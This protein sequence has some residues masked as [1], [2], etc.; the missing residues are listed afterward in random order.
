MIIDTGNI[1]LIGAVL[2]FFSI[3]AGK[4]GFRFGVPVLLLFL[5]VGML[6]GSDGLGIQFNNPHGAQFIGMIAL[7]I[8][9]FSGG[10]DTKYTEI[11]PVLGQGV[12]TRHPRGGTD[13]SHYRF[14]Y[15]LDYR[16][17]IRF[18]CSHAD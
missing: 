5:G 6:F 18:F 7:S 15:L 3:I 2:L 16:S 11:K 14:L 8:I 12:D 13:N 10:M 17:R 1:L 4:A 9:L